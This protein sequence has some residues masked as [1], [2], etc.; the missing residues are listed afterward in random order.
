[1]KRYSELIRIGS[2]ED[3]LRY[4][5]LGG[6]VGADTFGFDRYLNQMFYRDAE[7]AKIRRQV[8]LRDNGLDLAHPDRPIAGPVFVHHIE[9]ITK[10]DVLRR[11]A[12]LL[13]PD[14]LVCCSKQTH[15][16]IHYGAAADIK[17]LF[18]ERTP[19]DTC[20]WKLS[21]KERRL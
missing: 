4:L 9:P 5:L 20:P 3:R 2:F 1:M 10:D 7:W 8:I 6:T 11:S 16:R 18:V 12:V 14:N 15:D 17:P 19:N 13:D 21:G